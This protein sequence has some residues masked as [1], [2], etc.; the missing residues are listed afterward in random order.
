MPAGPPASPFDLP[1]GTAAMS[2]ADGVLVRGLPLA[3]G[4]RDGEAPR[5]LY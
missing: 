2:A 5:V 3:T 4:A 1:G